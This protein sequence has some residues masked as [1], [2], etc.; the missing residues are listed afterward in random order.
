MAILPV[1][2]DDIEFF[3]TIINPF[4]QYSSSSLGITGSIKLFPRGSRIEKEISPLSNFNSS[5]VNDEN[6]E[7]FRNDIANSAKSIPSGGSF[8]TSMDNYLS[9]VT[10]QSS[11]EKKK[12]QIYVN[13]FTPGVFFTSNTVRKLNVKDMLIPYYRSIYPTANWV[14]KN[15][16]SLNFF[17]ATGIPTSS[18][19]LYPSVEKDYLPAHDGYVS[20]TY[21]LSGA[22]SFDFHI[23]PRYQKDDIDAGHF[24][25]GTIFHLSSSYALSVVTGSN[26]DE[27]GL[28]VSFRLQLQLS[29]SADVQPSKA[30]AGSY[31]NNLIFLS[32]DNCLD[33]NKWHRVVVR[34]GTSLVNDGTGSFNINGIDRGTFVIPSGTIMP[35]VYSTKEDPRVLC[36]GN[37]YEG[38]N[39]A[40]S[41][42]LHFFSDV[43]STRE[44]LEQLVDSFGVQ[45]QPNSYSFNHP[46]K[47]EIHE[48][49][50]R[51]HYMND[52]QILQSSGSGLGTI[53]PLNVAFYVPPLFVENTPIRKW[54]SGHGGILQTPFFEI[55]GSTDDPF[56]VAMSFGVNGHYINLENF[57]KDFAN[58]VFPRLHH[59]S[60]T[61]IDYTTSAESANSFLYK[62]PFVKKRNLTILPCDDGLFAPNYSLLKQESG[63][64]FVNSF[65]QIDYSTIN[66]DNLLSTA[67]LLFGATHDVEYDPTWSDQQIGSTPENPGI[68]PGQAVLNVKK[69]IENIISTD[70]GAYGPGVHRDMP[71]TIYQRTKDQSSNQVTFFD[72][73]NLYYGSRILPG[74]FEIT[75]T[76]I[77]GSNGNIS[78]T[79]RDDGEGNIYR[80]DSSTPHA[81]WNSVG[82]IFYNEGV[83]LIKSPHL[84][85]FG[86]NQY[87]MSFKGEHQMHTQKYEILAS[88]GMIN[89]SSNPSYARCQTSISASADPL[90]EDKF[91]YISNINLHDE[92]LNVVAK[93]VLAQPI[94]KREGEKILFKVA[95]DF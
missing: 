6:L 90:D 15:Y 37:F 48:L 17:S 10:S 56:N 7:K 2:S 83:V 85:F 78:I 93:A 89:S 31:P 77:T 68:P 58:E 70:E 18:V 92:N 54:T 25:A 11:S 14:Y 61:A 86:S 62:D 30:I 72:I 36:V 51:R 33:W 5:F 19:L 53:D 84:Y 16:N 65:G 57:V 38:S 47:A 42:Q 35:K 52:K 43:V 32:D 39:I 20:G 40:A 28:P 74:S 94:M 9:K 55:D 45:D 49:T 71:L 64:K 60:G 66:L 88:S 23:N 46:L 59:L 91:V 69:K 26:K 81:N 24:K 82:N 34:W 3:T 1:T 95:F 73:S 8:Y 75:D 44:G 50:I 4:R 80:A 41:S 67:S 27:N 76:D 29:H 21:A 87:E 13:R 22:F 63:N 79:L 12:K